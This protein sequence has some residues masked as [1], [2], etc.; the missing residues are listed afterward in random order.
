MKK[1]L[2]LFFIIFAVGL[3]TY[4]FYKYSNPPEEPNTTTNS[5]ATEIQ[6]GKFSIEFNQNKFTYGEEE[7]LLKELNECD[8]SAENDRDPFNPACSPRF[9]KFF[10]LDNGA[11]LKN[12]FILLIKATVRGSET[13]KTKIFQREK[14][15]LVLVNGFNGTL[16]ERRKSATKYDDL[17]IRFGNRIDNTLHHFNCLF[18]WN[19]GK[20]LYDSCERINDNRVKKEFKDSMN[21]DIKSMLEKEHYLF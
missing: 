13:R 12:G 8:S 15:V 17:V 1:F 18:K 5:S 7:D 20:Y 11:T 19:G 2:V 6:R 14:G 3:I 16:I 4:L 10:P 21:L 9:F